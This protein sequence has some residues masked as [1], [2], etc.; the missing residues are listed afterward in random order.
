[1]AGCLFRCAVA[2]VIFTFSG[3]SSGTL[4]SMGPGG[5]VFIVLLLILIEL[6][7]SLHFSPEKP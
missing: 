6:F 5:W 7:T 1:M 4:V 2:V 3:G